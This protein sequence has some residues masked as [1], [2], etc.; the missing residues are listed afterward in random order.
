MIY[1]DYAANSPVDKRVLDKFY[2]ITLNYYANPNSTHKLG[3][4][5]K[6]IIDNETNKIASLLN[7]DKDTIIYT[8]GAS[9]SN[10]LVIKGITSRYKG[11]H[12]IISP[13]EHSSII[14]PINVLQEQGYD[15][16]ILQLDDNGQIDL[17][18]L[19]ELINDN[20]VLVSICAVD[21]EL[22]I[23]QPINE[24]QSIVDKYPNCFYH[25]DA[26]QS[27]GKTQ[28][29]YSNIDLVTI[30]PHKFYGM[31]GFGGLIKKK[32]IKLT[33]LIHGG[34]STT[35]FRSGTPIPAN[36]VAFS[37]ALDLAINNFKERN[38]YI[39]ELSN[40][41]KLRLASYK[42][43]H[44]NSTKYSIPSTINF[45]IL[46]KN[47][48]LFAKQLEEKDIYV[49]TK[50]ACSIDELPSSAVY[51]VTKNKEY[52]SSSI[53]ISISHLTTKEEIDLFFKILDEINVYD[54]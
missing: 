3:L 34:K 42:N 7:V 48:H 29:D 31:N 18:Q 27:I 8:S 39:E 50:S 53:R 46:N 25:C 36:V 30:A 2:D 17:K 11:K 40:Y 16:D 23:V 21:S 15:I 49:S 33:P 24:I 54:K 32:N 43:F 1:L 19:Q 37:K 52:A 20:T 6:E 4:E 14:A 38:I 41:I 10:N 12:I 35:V 51:A 45:S 44:I 28:L 47:S 26:S 13:L 9:E 5:A 22:G